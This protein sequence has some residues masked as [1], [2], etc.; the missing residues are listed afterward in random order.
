MST[1]KPPDGRQ[2]K[3]AAHFQL[4][5]AGPSDPVSWRL[6]SGNNREVGRGS[7]TYHDAEECLVGIK[8]LVARISDVTV[9]VRRFGLRSWRW[10]LMQDG[11]L[12]AYSAHLFDRRIR[13]EQA[14]RRFVIDAPTALINPVVALSNTRRWSLG[15]Q[16][17]AGR[18][19]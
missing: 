4:Y 19:S 16:Q 5:G 8:D 17:S 15:I 6:L 13:C 1:D 9:L 3:P 2:A 10:S 11:V 18:P 14:A 12:V 7:A